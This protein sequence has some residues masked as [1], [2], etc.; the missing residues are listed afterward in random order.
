VD[1]TDW[2]Q[3]VEWFDELIRLTDNPIAR[4]N[5]AVAVGEADGPRAAL[6]A[7]ATVDDSLPR[8][9]AVAAHLHERD[10]DLGVASRLYSRAARKASNPAERDHLTRQ[11]ARLNAGRTD[12][13]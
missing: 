7:L 2:T 6:A 11:A 4:L 3:I 8:Y 1:Q 5:R 9:D 10:G 12:D 13:V